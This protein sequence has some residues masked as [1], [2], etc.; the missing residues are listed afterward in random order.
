MKVAT[1]HSVCECQAGLSAD[2]DEKRSV[3]RGSARD[4][5]RNRVLSAPANAMP[6][7]GELFN[8]GWA[9]PLC[10]RNVLR[11]FTTSALSYREA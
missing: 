1:V 10:T 3:L 7:D 4:P 6:G 9:C 5:A 11:S 8:V 2:L